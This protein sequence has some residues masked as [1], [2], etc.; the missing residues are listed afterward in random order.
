MPYGP[1]VPHMFIVVFLI[2]LPIYLK[3]H[4]PLLAW[5]LGAG[6]VPRH[7]R[8]R[9]VGRLCRSYG[10]QIH[11]TSCHARH[12]RRHF[13]RVHLDAAGIPRL[14]GSL[15]VH[16]VADNRAGQLDGRRPTALWPAG[17]PRGGGARHS[18]RLAGKARS[19]GRP[20]AADGGC[21]RPWSVR[22][23]SAVSVN[24]LRQGDRRHRAAARHCRATRHLQLH[25]GHE[26]R[27][28]RCRRG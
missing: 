1:S 5:R 6:V 10:A 16:A 25:R 21:R 4:E 15:A 12:A 22:L 11:A 17:R 3:T 2:M 20:N 14:G 23:S 24:R 28:E 19:S 18:A 9:A 13:H 7:R 8:H 26:Q 27:G